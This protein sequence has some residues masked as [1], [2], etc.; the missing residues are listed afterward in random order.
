[1]AGPPAMR[2]ILHEAV[3]R[4]SCGALLMLFPAV[5]AALGAAVAPAHAQA[6]ACGAPTYAGGN[7]EVLAATLD[8]GQGTVGSAT[9]ATGYLGSGPGAFGALA[10]ARFSAGGRTFTVNV[11]A[12]DT[13]AGRLTL[14]LSATPTR[15]DRLT[16]YVCDA[17]FP[18]SGRLAAAGTGSN[19]FVLDA[20]DLALADGAERRIRIGHDDVAPTLVSTRR[21][22][23]RVTLTWSEA[24]DRTRCR[25]RA[26][27]G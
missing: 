15:A 4:P 9:T 11:L 2:G 19:T 25:P 3:P 12:H 26:R 20:P 21:S 16:L 14:S 23:T 10:P 22:G 24:L 6:D 1:M 13:G 5:L 17:A 27:S 18:L 7:R 8:A